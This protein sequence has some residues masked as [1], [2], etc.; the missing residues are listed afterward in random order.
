MPLKTTFSVSAAVVPS[1]LQG[2]R[3]HPAI[4]R[5]RPVAKRVA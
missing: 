2:I 4:D 5:I 3:I 1:D